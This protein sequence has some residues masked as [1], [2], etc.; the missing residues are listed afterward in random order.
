MT[1]CRV[2]FASSLHS[3]AG[4]LTGAAITLVLAGCQTPQEQH[5]VAAEQRW[6]AARADVKTRLAAEQL[7]AGQVAAAATALADAYRLTPDSPDLVP[8]RAR[9]LL[10]DGQVTAAQQVLAEAQAR[11]VESA[12]IQYLTGVVCEEQHEVESAATAYERAVQLNP[13]E[14]TYTLALAQSW[15]QLHRAGDALAFLHTVA[16]RFD[17]TPGYHATLAECQE[18]LGNWSAAA[19]SWRRVTAARDADE[20]IQERLATALY[21]AQ[22]YAD[23]VP[24]L[25]QL[26]ASGGAQTPA[27]IRLMLADAYLAQGRIAEACDQARQVLQREPDQRPALRLLARALATDGQI[28]EALRVA[29]RAVAADPQ[30]VNS[31][32]L[33]AGLAWRSG[34][35]IL[36][37]QT[38]NTLR[39]RDVDNAIAARI[40]SHDD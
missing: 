10:A 28:G 21:A 3:F 38:A 15:L 22:Q 16:T 34:D 12:E 32:E 31:L 17:F 37:T 36:A 1:D 11:G 23:A 20:T 7:A 35:T 39:Q 19:S 13:D 8:L 18:Q 5:R 25:N 24:V 26:V 6:D 2:R 27:R 29:Q 40:L 9:V 4:L 14:L 30:D 33:V